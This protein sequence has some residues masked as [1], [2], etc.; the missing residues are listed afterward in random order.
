MISCTNVRQLQSI[1]RTSESLIARGLGRC[2]GDSSLN[3]KIVSMLKMNRIPSFDESTGVIEC[4]AGVSFAELIEL[5]VPR[6]WFLP[7]TPGTKFVTVGGAIAADIHGKNHHVSGSF[8]RHTRSIVLMTSEGKLVRCSRQN[9]PALFWATCGGMGL[10]GIIISA[11]FQLLRIQSA[12]MAQETIKTR[13]IDEVLEAFQMSQSWTYSVAWIDCYAKGNSFGRSLLFRGEHAS[14]ERVRAE[15]LKGNPLELRHAFSLSVPFD[16]PAF[17][18]S[19]PMLKLV[20]AGIY[21]LRKSG[22]SQQFVGLDE[23]FYP[24]DRIHR[25]NRMY[26]KQGL[27]QYQFVLP[28]ATSREGITKVL[29]EVSN[30]RYGSFLAVLKLFGKQE[31]MLSFPQEGYTL[32]LDF[33]VSKELFPFLDRLDRIVLEHGGKLYLAKDGRMSKNMFAETYVQRR[34]FLK[35][36][37]RTD[38]RNLFQSL[39]SARVGLS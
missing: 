35:T 36:K 18:L 31:G 29:H 19:Q 17:V 25:W 26:G 33:P 24:L 9:D 10:T 2:Y 28:K 23:F 21:G 20:N 30:F 32:A 1:V 15:G 6:G 5:L 12:F 14:E 8:S 39:Q 4:E 37:R 13:N 34:V 7:V 16:L 22:M 27:V 38:R 11:S 3:G